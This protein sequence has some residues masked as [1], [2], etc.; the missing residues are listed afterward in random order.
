VPLDLPN[1]DNLTWQ[2]LAEEGRS[3][4]PGWAPEWTNH[5]AADPGITLVE[6]FA[7][8]SEIL[9]YRLNRISAANLWAF[10][11]LI[12]GPDWQPPK[13]LDEAK[14]GTLLD[15]RRTCRAVTAADFERLALDI[16]KTLGPK[17][18]EKVA[19][20]KAI[21]RRNLAGD[22]L[23]S[24]AP[25]YVSVV[26]VA[27]VEGG[28][29]EPSAELLERVRKELEPARLLTTRV[30]VVKPRYVSFR[31]RVTLVVAM[32]ESIG[33]VRQSVIDALQEFFDPLKGGPQAEG[34][35]FGRDVYLSEVYQL[36]ARLPG[37]RLVRRSFDPQTRQSLE[38]LV[39]TDSGTDRR[40][41]SQEGKL[42]AIHLDSDEL[43]RAQIQKADIAVVHEDEGQG[44]E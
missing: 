36:L 26:V 1:L 22:D 17:A 8:L 39:V 32:T 25:G 41:F 31:V 30:H 10:L 37:V 42:E 38:E 44:A 18:K 20:A 40:R 23:T 7:Y 6:L 29:T 34:W 19:R 11:R 15:L 27:S 16:N 3:L 2:Q 33:E 24:D 4:I 12:N 13:A 43:V 14:R 21:F 9:I 35:P 28:G 5:N